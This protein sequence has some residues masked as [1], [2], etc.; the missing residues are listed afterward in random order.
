MVFQSQ[1]SC[2]QI[3]GG[4]VTPAF[5]IILPGY[6]VQLYCTPTCAGLSALNRI[7]LF[8]GRA[9]FLVNLARAR[10]ESC[11]CCASGFATAMTTIRNVSVLSP[12]PRALGSALAEREILRPR[13]GPCRFR[14]GEDQA[15][16]FAIR[17]TDVQYSAFHC[18]SPAL[19]RYTLHARSRSRVSPRTRATYSLRV[20]YTGGFSDRSELCVPL[21]CA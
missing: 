19:E 13:R 7:G 11:R 2:I 21:A 10:S 12:A 4:S 16:T 20:G 3:Y 18:R 6:T 17:V 5:Y 8:S 1:F 9:V 15:A 14:R